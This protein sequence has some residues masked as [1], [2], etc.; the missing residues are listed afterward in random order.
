MSSAREFEVTI[1]R[2]GWIAW[3]WRVLILAGIAGGAFLVWAGFLF[4]QPVSYFI[5]APLL[6][7]S[8]FFGFVVATRID[9]LDDGV[10]LVTT[11]LFK[12]RRIQRVDL[13]TPRVHFYAQA[14][15]SQVY[16][17]R[18]WIPV[19]GRWPIYLD[20]MAEIP[21]RSAFAN[22]FG[23]KKADLPRSRA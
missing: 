19:R 3:V 7:P 20:L 4:A 22:T 21:D 15:A 12:R 16:A 13:G 17:P 5:A 6:L 9:R 10:L 14:T 1:Y 18:S 2:Y 11:L 23:I 8:V